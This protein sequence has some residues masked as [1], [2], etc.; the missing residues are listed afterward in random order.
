MGELPDWYSLITAARYLKVAPWVL[1][2]Q[3]IAWREWALEA[4]AA[5]AEAR[6][7]MRPQPRG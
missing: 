7:A 6:Q 3:P 5:E 1:A 2:Q 4:Q